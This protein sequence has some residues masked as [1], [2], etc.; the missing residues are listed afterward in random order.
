[1]IWEEWIVKITLRVDVVR[2]P[3][4]WGG[5]MLQGENEASGL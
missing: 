1:M 2:G 4:G 3:G 5:A